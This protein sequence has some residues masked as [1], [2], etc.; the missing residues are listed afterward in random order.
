[1]EA[2]VLLHNTE[3]QRYEYRIGPHIAQIEYLT[4]EDGTIYLTHTRIP[5]ALGGQGIGTSLI[6]DV[7]QDIDRQHLR[8]VP[9]CPFISSYIRKHPEWEPLVATSRAQNQEEPHQP[10]SDS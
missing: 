5:E 3:E 7:L 2:P 1:M 6:R 4:A 10:V 9:V 8:I